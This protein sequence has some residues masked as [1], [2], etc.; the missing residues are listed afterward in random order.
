[1]IK[2]NWLI[3]GFKVTHNNQNMGSVKAFNLSNMGQPPITVKYNEQFPF[4]HTGHI[5]ALGK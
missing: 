3:C 1:M 2:H 5:W 4:C